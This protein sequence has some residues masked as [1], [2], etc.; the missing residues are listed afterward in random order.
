MFCEKFQPVNLT[1]DVGEVMTPL[2]DITVNV[3]L[4]YSPRC[5]C[6]VNNVCCII[7]YDEVT[8]VGKYPCS[9][10]KPGEKVLMELSH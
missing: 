2:G 9:H 5:D 1:R 10:Q 7:H 6:D 3:Y 8:T 4:I